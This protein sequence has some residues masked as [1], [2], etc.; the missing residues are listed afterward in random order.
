M[1]LNNMGVGFN[2]FGRDTG[3]GK[4]ISKT[5]GAFAGLSKAASGAAKSAGAGLVGALTQSQKGLIGASSEMS[6]YTTNVEQSAVAASKAVKAATVGIDVQGKSLRKFHSDVQGVV[7]GLVSGPEEAAEAWSRFY[8]YGLDPAKKEFKD[9]FGSF[10]RMMRMTRVAIGD[11]DAFTNAIGFLRDELHKSP[12]EIKAFIEYGL[13]ATSALNLGKEGMDMYIRSIQTY[14]D[15]LSGFGMDDKEIDRLS[16]G[17]VVLAGFYRMLNKSPKEA[18][19]ATLQTTKAILESNRDWSGMFLGLKDDLPDLYKSL[20]ENM[21]DSAKALESYRKDP[22]NFLKTIAD[23]VTK[24][25]NLSDPQIANRLM[26]QLGGIFEPATIQLLRDGKMTG[27]AIVEMTKKIE[28]SGETVVSTAKKFDAGITAQQ[29]YQ[30]VLDQTHQML[31]NVAGINDHKFVKSLKNAKSELKANMVAM[32]QNNGA[33]GLL[34]DTIVETSEH[35]LGGL[36]GRLNP[37]FLQMNLL[38]DRFGTVA[39]SI[40]GMGSALVSIGKNPKKFADEVSK[41]V[42][43]IKSKLSGAGGMFNELK[44]GWDEFIK[45]AG[46]VVVELYNAFADPKDKAK[47]PGEALSKM[48]Q[49]AFAYLKDNIPK[50]WGKVQE[51]LMGLYHQLGGSEEIKT[52]GGA[53]GQM[54]SSLWEKA[55]PYIKAGLEKLGDALSDFLVRT[56]WK[57]VRAMPGGSA[58]ERVFRDLKP[59]ILTSHEPEEPRRLLPRGMT[60]IPLENRPIPGEKAPK[61]KPAKTTKTRPP[62]TSAPA[63]EA[64]QAQTAGSTKDI[65]DQ[66]EKAHVLRKTQ[67]GLLQQAVELLA[68]IAGEAPYAKPAPSPSTTGTK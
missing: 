53:L 57:I 38:Q 58:V 30:R 43:S 25:R 24:A 40:L 9:I 39:G 50:W 23:A 20:M 51:V 67:V 32:K 56:Y 41:M 26:E 63:A 52:L 36:L 35:G 28:A 14:R 60:T 42:A 55:E 68:K 11:Q 1:G 2:F 61:L 54:F 44:K 5:Q 45:Q 27:D 48:F 22:I 3:L 33:M 15:S 21:G 46:N 4:M 13:K 29:E 17:S 59:E 10:D 19:D 12:K 64:T 18:A 65:A 6:V 16:K 34:F 31:K 37:T 7:Y 49:A 62:E 47:T 66:G 8:R